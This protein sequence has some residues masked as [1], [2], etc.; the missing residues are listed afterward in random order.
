MRLIR[1]RDRSGGQSLVEF[2]LVVPIFFLLLFG[3]IDVGRYVYTTT[4]YGQAA[5]EGARYGSVDQW[6]YSCPGS[7]ASQ[8][9]TNCTVAV[10]L[11]RVPAGAP[12]PTTVTFTCPAT[13]RAGDLIAVRVRGQFTFFTPVISNLLGS[14]WVDQ[15]TQV[16]IQ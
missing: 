13:C 9:R 1:H 5:R 2:A 7:V 12:V 10:T 16:V 11:S 4:A 6:S 8:T 15:T 3:F 14:P